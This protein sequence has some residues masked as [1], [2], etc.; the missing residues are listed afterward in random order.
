MAYYRRALESTPES[1][2]LRTDLG[3]AYNRLNRK[4]EAIAEFLKVLEY[5]PG[6]LTAM[7]NLGVV[8]EQLGEVEKAKEWY[9]RV[10]ETA[11]ASALGRSASQHLNALGG[12]I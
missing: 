9:G 7:F 11:P 4:Q 5:N 2:E 6:F 10:V 3:T 12:G 8:H 1:P